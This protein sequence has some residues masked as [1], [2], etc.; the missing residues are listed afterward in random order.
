MPIGISTG[1]IVSIAKNTTAASP[2]FVTLPNVTS[3]SVPSMTAA[4]IETTTIGST[5][6]SF[7][8]GTQDN[9]TIEIAFQHERTSASVPSN[10][11]KALMLRV[12][13]PNTVT[14]Q[15]RIDFEFDQT[16]VGSTFL[17]LFC[18]AHFMSATIEGSIDELVG[19]TMTYRISGAITY[20]V[21][22]KS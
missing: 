5:T 21:V 12:P 6:K 7:I 2:T 11:I 20:T 14:D 4:E 18:N 19:G 17:R 15:I 3:I 16:A 1:T 22:T 9:G 10:D 8:M 13:A